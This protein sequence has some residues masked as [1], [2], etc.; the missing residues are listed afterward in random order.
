MHL[1]DRIRAAADRLTAR[2]TLVGADSRDDEDLRDRKALL[3]LIS[4]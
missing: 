4:V 2:L 3:V 1:L